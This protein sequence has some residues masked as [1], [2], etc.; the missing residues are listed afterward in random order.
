LAAGKW[1]AELE[2]SFARAHRCRHAIAVSNGTTA[3]V[4]ALRAHGVGPG[5]EVITSPLTFVATLNCILEVGATARFADITEDFTLDPSALSALA[6]PR[7][8]AVIPVH[9]YGLPAAMPEISEIARR[10]GWAIIE[11]AAQAPGA[12]V[13]GKPVGSFGTA[14][15][16][17]YATKNITCGEGGLVTA[18][19]DEIAKRLRL[20]RNH[21]M[22]GRYD[23]SMPGY[24]Y[25]LTDLQAAIAVPQL[26]KLP[27]IRAA[28]SRNAGLLSA[29]LTGLP[30]LVLPGT[31]DG[32]HHAW[33]QYTVRVTPQA[34]MDRDQLRK[35]LEEAGVDTMVYYPK[36]VHDY[37]CYRDHPRV[38]QDETPRAGRAAAEVLSLPVHPA[39]TGGDIDRIVTCVREALD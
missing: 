39:L 24:N 27:G 29:G 10:H 34:R 18:N 37:R 12:H 1:V 20:L 15:F 21:G 5:D 38:V 4:L 16:S 19:D 22:R 30:G 28:R 9:L 11:D 7:T 32:R 33:H 35:C 3:L 23:Y 8:K 6:S 13:A 31:P 25:R 14:A 2:S 26:R 17:L 36:L